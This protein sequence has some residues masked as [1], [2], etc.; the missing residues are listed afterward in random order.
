[1]TAT[2]RLYA[3]LPVQQFY[4]DE[5]PLFQEYLARQAQSLTYIPV[6][7]PEQV[8]LRPDGTT[9]RGGYRFTLWSM[10]QLCRLA[11]PYA[12][13]MLR[14]VL[15]T[16]HPDGP[17]QAAAAVFNMIARYVLSGTT[18]L[19]LLVDTDTKTIYAVVKNFQVSDHLAIWSGLSRTLSTRGYG[20]WFHGA[21]VHGLRLVCWLRES[22]PS[23]EVGCRGEAHA[24]YRGVYARLVAGDRVPVLA[25]APAILCPGGSAIGVLRMARDIGTQEYIEWTASRVYDALPD[26]E[27]VRER[28]QGWVGRPLLPPGDHSSRVVGNRVRS[29]RKSLWRAGLGHD[30]AAAVVAAVLASRRSASLRACRRLQ[31]QTT[32]DVVDAT[33]RFARR[34]SRLVRE[35]TEQAAYG[36]LIGAFSLEEKDDT[37]NLGATCR[38]GDLQ[39]NPAA[40]SCAGRDERVAATEVLADC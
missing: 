2:A 35:R 7:G 33:L 36:L 27:A 29:L 32:Y 9:Q 13:F 21:A 16:R 10:R 18:G 28:V 22:R 14:T 4:P 20:F 1:M 38:S 11:I 23:F 17:V 30:A 6:L 39:C 15:A 12:N 34:R 5:G 19:A 26:M 31:Y 40:T 24:F 25:V 37:P 8:Y 3:D